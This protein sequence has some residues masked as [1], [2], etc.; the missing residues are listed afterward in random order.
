MR[1][2]SALFAG[3]FLGAVLRVEV[4]ELAPVHAGAWPW[5]TFTVNVA[6]AFVLGW[7][8]VTTAAGGVRR[9]L[10]GA[11]FCGALTTFSTVQVEL[12]GMLDRGD[13]SLA[14]GYALASVAAGLVG[15]RA[16]TGLAR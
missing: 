8:M 15:V 4:A 10:F 2:T 16:A 7:I 3:G 1:T 14:A 9:P 11:G 5:A 6:G 13:L 12:L